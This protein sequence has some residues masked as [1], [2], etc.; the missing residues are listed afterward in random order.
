MRINAEAIKDKWG[1]NPIRNK[2]KLNK[3]HIILN[4]LINYLARKHSGKMRKKKKA[5]YQVTT[6]GAQVAL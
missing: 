6:T 5:W 4:R 2:F 3:L 1:G